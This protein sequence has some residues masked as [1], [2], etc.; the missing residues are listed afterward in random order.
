MNEKQ[1]RVSRY[2]QAVFQI[3]VEK[4]QSSLNE[5]SAAVAGDGSL[6]ALLNDAAADASTKIAALEQALPSGLPV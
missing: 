2:A 3:M 6:S 4:W 1:A 5:V